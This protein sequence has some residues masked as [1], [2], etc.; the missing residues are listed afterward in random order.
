MEDPHR[1]VAPV[2]NNNNNNNNSNNNN[3]DYYCYYYNPY[4]KNSVYLCLFVLDTFPQRC[5]YFDQIWRDD[6]GHA[7]GV[8][9]KLFPFPFPVKKTSGS[10]N[11]VIV[12]AMGFLL[13]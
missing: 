3:C 6:R 10:W 8:L 2:K 5:A 9:A 13:R 12:T 1:V 4:I 7:W 11:S